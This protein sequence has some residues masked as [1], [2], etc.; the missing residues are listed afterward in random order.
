M[1]GII[2]VVL[3]AHDTDVPVWYMG[4]RLW[5]FLVGDGIIAYKMFALLG[6]VLS[7]LLG[8]TV[9]RKQWGA[10]TAALLYDF[11]KFD[12][13]NDEDQCEQQNVFLDGVRSYCLRIDCLFFA[14][15]HEQAGPVD[16]IVLDYFL[17]YFQSLLYRVQLPVYLPVS[18]GGDLAAGHKN[19]SGSRLCV[20][21]PLYCFSPVWLIKIDFF[22]C[23]FLMET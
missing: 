16:D 12:T 23:W 19:R 8:P 10:K 22:I 17:R 7:M 13:G 11:G 15:A 20:V 5:S 1:M 18:G 4:L 3:D 6:T 21:V 14:G 9:I 2:R